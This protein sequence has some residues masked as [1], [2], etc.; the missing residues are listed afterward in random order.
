MSATKSKNYV[1]ACLLTGIF[2]VNRNELIA[3]DNFEVVQKWYNSMV[4]LKLNAV[5]FHNSFSDET[6]SKF[7]NEYVK[8]EKVVQNDSFNPNINRYF[9]YQDYITNHQ[10]EINNL[11]LTDISDV[12]VILNPFEHNYFKANKNKIFCGDENK[13]L[14]NDWMHD[15][16]LHLRNEITNFVAFEVENQDKTLLNCGVIGGSKT[17]ILE[18]LNKITSLHQNYSLSNKTPFTLD[19]GVFNYVM[20]TFFQNQFLH[21]NPINTVFKNYETNRNDCWFCHK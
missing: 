7:E 21:G 6:V 5:L 10:A 2:D 3:D 13:I 12:T 19:M 1:F 17:I 20:Y 4:D 18:L 16:C 15:H 11:F 9:V 14:N 8:F